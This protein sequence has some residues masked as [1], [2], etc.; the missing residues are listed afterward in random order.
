MN[1]K[2]ASKK[3]DQSVKAKTAPKKSG[4]LLQQLFSCCTSS[5]KKQDRSSDKPSKSSKAT[6]KPRKNKVQESIKRTRSPT[7]TSNPEQ[8]VN[9]K[10]KSKRSKT[11]WKKNSTE[12]EN[13]N[14]S[15][16]SKDRETQKTIDKENTETKLKE[17]IENKEKEQK[18]NKNERRKRKQKER[19]EKRER[20]EK[21]EKERRTMENREDEQKVT[22]KKEMEK[23]D[24]KGT[25]IIKEGKMKRKNHDLIYKTANVEN[26]KNIESEAF[27]KSHNEDKKFASFASSST[28]VG[29]L[30]SDQRELPAVKI[31]PDFK[32]EITN[33][34]YETSPSISVKKYNELPSTSY[35][36]YAPVD[37]HKRIDIDGPCSGYCARY[38]EIDCT[39]KKW[40]KFAKKYYKMKLEGQ[41]CKSQKRSKYPN[42]KK[43]SHPTFKYILEENWKKLQNKL[44]FLRKKS[45]KS[46][47]K[48]YSRSHS[49]SER[50]SSKCEVKYCPSEECKE[51]QSFRKKNKKSKEE[52]KIK[53]KVKRSSKKDKACSVRSSLELITVCTTRRVRTKKSTEYI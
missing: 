15:K 27:S 25:Q 24:L 45:Q 34:P 8:I 38:L 4:G 20:E 11:K 37:N 39:N 46:S 47:K 26:T 52:S 43:E 5:E 7:S 40:K 35:Q 19:K 33:L 31:G 36:L 49:S 44:P 23:Q 14:E 12:K 6:A 51:P 50:E 28:A 48:R 9:C 16:E 18:E 41:T 42:P 22:I 53:K 30:Y 3:V 17:S 1:S 2:A 32:K 29:G 13:E 21:E 10:R